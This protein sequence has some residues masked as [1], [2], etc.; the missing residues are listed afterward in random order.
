MKKKTQE[1]LLTAPIDVSD[2]IPDRVAIP[3]AKR[4]A[5]VLTV[6]AFWIAVLIYFVI[7]GGGTRL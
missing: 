7:A 2:G 3:A 6:Y 1:R 5:I 4:L